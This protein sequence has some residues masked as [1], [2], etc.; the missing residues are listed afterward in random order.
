MEVTIEVFGPSLP[1]KHFEQNHW[2]HLRNHYPQG[3]HSNNLGD[4]MP[5]GAIGLARHNWPQIISK[6]IFREKKWKR[7]IVRYRV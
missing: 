1:R 2:E 3:I 6:N 4:F 5:R 7:Y